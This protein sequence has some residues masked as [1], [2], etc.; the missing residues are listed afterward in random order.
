MIV[1]WSFAGV[2]SLLYLAVSWWL[3]RGIARCERSEEIVENKTTIAVLVAARN[4]EQNLPHLLESLKH[5][6]YDNFLVTIMIIDDRSSDGTTRVI[7]HYQES[8]PNLYSIRVE[9]VPSGIAPKKNAI[10]QGIQATQS[11]LIVVTDADCR[12]PP[13]WLS[14]LST[15]FADERVGLVQGL[16]GYTETSHKQLFQIFQTVDFFSHSVVA[17]AGIGRNFPINSNANNFAYRRTVFSDIGGYGDAESVVSGDDDLLLQKVWKSGMWKIVYMGT[18][19]AAVAT[20]APATFAE[21][22][23]QRKRWGSKTIYYHGGQVA[24][25]GTIFLFYL[26]VVASTII[27]LLSNMNSATLLISLYGAKIVGELFFM[28]PGAR[29][30]KKNHIVKHV[31]WTSIIQLYTVVFSVLGG[32]FGAF[33]WKGE[34]FRRKTGQ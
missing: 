15:R 34:T 20:E 8:M 28:I 31:W 26:T 32:V 33:T 21:M 7:Q 2:V 19:S 14:L 4:E 5:Q 25:L 1:W 3:S 10:L 29:M 22:I 24:L 23:D 9:S 13:R 18:P 11:D 30:F 12:V 6:T 17:A 16:T 27:V